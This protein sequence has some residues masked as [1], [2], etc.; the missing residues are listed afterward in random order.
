MRVGAGVRERIVGPGEPPFVIAELGV[1]HDGSPERAL[2]LVDL[3]AD[4]GADAIKLQFFE[5]DRLMSGA[6]RLAAYQVHAGE[7]DPLSMLRRLE[8]PIGDLERIAERA[9]A[10][11]LS[12]ILTVFS[13]ELVPIAERVAWDAYKSASPDVIHRPLLEAMAG[14]GRPLIVSTGAATGDEV[15]RARAWLAEAVGRLAFLHCISSYPTPPEHAHLNMIG[16]VARLAAPCPVGYSDHTPMVETGAVARARGATILEKHFTDDR[17]RPG[18]DHAA[19]LEPEDFARYVRAARGEIEI[20]PNDRLLG[21]STKH[22]IACEADVQRV[23]RQSLVAVRDL[24]PGE[25]LARADLTVKRPGTGLPPFE[26]GSVIGR[27]VARA[28]RADHPLAAADLVG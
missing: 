14:T 28:V 20:T 2:A 8:M 21:D 22:P 26:I 4:A 12:A 23:S 13:T 3:A 7:T 25:V 11:G 6:S 27:R 9:H 15:A 18:P 16:D 17:T 19:S 24:D 10:R 5:T 1:N